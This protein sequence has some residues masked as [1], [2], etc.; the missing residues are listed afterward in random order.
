LPSGNLQRPS[1]SSAKVMPRRLVTGSCSPIASASSVIPFC[2]PVLHARSHRRF[3]R[4]RLAYRYFSLSPFRLSISVEIVKPAAWSRGWWLT[5]K[6]T[7]SPSIKRVAIIRPRLLISSASHPPRHR[8]QVNSTPAA[9]RA[10]WAR[11]LGRP[12]FWTTGF[13]KKRSGRLGSKNLNEVFPHLGF[14][15]LVAAL[16][17][18]E[19]KVGAYLTAES[20]AYA[21]C[22]HSRG[23][24][25]CR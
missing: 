25:A 17:A 24:K 7:P 9:S 13:S 8:S 3:R 14:L 21:L 4:R 1:R 12:C 22:V 20:S 16:G 10:A 2:F 19:C 6:Y 23:N 15:A 11:L 18:Q 5:M